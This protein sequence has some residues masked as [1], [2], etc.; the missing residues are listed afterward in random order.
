[1]SS[2]FTEQLLKAGLITE[3]KIEQAEQEKKAQKQKRQ[4]NYKQRNNNTGTK[5]SETKAHNHPQK[6]KKIK[7]QKNTDDLAQFY[8]ARKKVEN[9]ERI[10]AEEKQKEE[11]RLRKERR[12]KIKALT[13]KH[14]IKTTDAD[15]R[16]NFLIDNKVKYTFVTAEQQD[17]L[18][19]GELAITFYANSFTLLPRE[20]GEA[21]RTIDPA[22][23]LFIPEAED[24]S[25]T[26]STPA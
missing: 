20:I 6:N 11:S 1:M 22:K 9:K 25:L 24:G 12:E 23:L 16:Y 2:S 3:D 21:I 13:I 8:Q 4:Q 14:R 15:I 10:Q 18:I 5:Q 26:P 19:K 7:T 17:Q